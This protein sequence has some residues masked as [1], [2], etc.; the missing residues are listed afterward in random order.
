MGELW[1]HEHEL[2]PLSAAASLAYFEL[3]EVKGELGSEE[4]LG[5][6]I[7]L[8]AIALSQLAPIRSRTS[9]LSAAEV[10]ELLFSPVRKGRAA[11]SLENFYILKSDLRAAIASLR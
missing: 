1:S 10:K 2:L 7:E 9:V 3:T 6:V 11:P 5:E 4:H 8:V